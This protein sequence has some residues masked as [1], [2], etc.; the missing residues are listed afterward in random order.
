MVVTNGSIVSSIVTTHGLI[1]TNRQYNTYGIDCCLRLYSCL[2]YPTKVAW[3]EQQ[4]QLQLWHPNNISTTIV[5]LW[6]IHFLYFTSIVNYQHV[7]HTRLSSSHPTHSPHGHD[8]TMLLQPVI[9][10][11][12]WHWLLSEVVFFIFTSIFIYQYISHARTPII[13]T[14]KDLHCKPLQQDMEVQLQRLAV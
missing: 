13:I 9:V 3:G 7:S 5:L 4:T 6:V 2:R 11:C 1:D 14:Y 8:Q 12:V 10:R